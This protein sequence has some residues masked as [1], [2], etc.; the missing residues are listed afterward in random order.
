MFE[1]IKISRFR[2][3]TRQGSYLLGWFNVYF[4]AIDLDIEGFTAYH[5][6]GQKWFNL[7]S[8]EYVDKDSG[9]KKYPNTMRF[10]DEL[11]YRAFM[12]ALRKAFDRFCMEQAGPSAH[13]PQPPQE[14]EQYAADNFK[15]DEELPF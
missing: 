15:Q 2:K 12:E 10:P 11:T 3:N 6:N 9:E 8:R 1:D 14:P 4:P 13:E 5:K 7:P